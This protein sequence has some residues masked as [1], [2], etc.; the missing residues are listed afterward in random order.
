MEYLLALL[1]PPL[2]LLVWV[3]V[4]NAW[5]RRFLPAD[6]DDDALAGRSSLRA[7]RMRETLRAG[8]RRSPGYNEEI[9][10]MRLDDYN[11]ED[12]FEATGALE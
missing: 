9:L 10:T 12:R 5:R 3:G 1:L 2:L 7:M 6:S 4:Q 11:K 8:R